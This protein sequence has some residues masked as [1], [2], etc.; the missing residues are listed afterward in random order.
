MNEHKMGCTSLIICIFISS[1]LLSHGIPFF[2]KTG[3]VIGFF[4]GIALL[5]GSFIKFLNDHTDGSQ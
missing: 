1:Q 2:G 4:I 3:S 5:F